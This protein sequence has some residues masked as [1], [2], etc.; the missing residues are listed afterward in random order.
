MTHKGVTGKTI[1]DGLRSEFFII[2]S[3]HVTQGAELCKD[4]QTASLDY[5]FADHAVELL[6]VSLSVYYKSDYQR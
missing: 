6:F 1:R 3:L 4:P 2:R 5:A